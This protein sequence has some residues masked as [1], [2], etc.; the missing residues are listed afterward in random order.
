ME[1]T[2]SQFSFDNSTPD[3]Q[4][5]PVSQVSIPETAAPDW[6]NANVQSQAHHRY[7]D[8]SIEAAVQQ[9]GQQEVAAQK[10]RSQP[11]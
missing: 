9:Q 7:T 5:P 4:A 10:A 1:D 11:V 6:V 3:T 2:T 8:P